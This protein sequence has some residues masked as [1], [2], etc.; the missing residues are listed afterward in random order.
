MNAPSNTRD[1]LATDYF[2]VYGLGSLGQGCVMNLQKFASQACPIRITA[3]DKVL[4]EKLTNVTAPG[5]LKPTLII[6]DYRDD[7]ILEQAGIRRC[8]SIL[9]LSDDENANIE[10]AFAA[11]R[12]NPLM[13]LVVRSS[14]P[15]LNRLLE[16]QLTNCAALDAAEL[17]ATAFAVAG[18]GNG[19]IGAFSIDE[20]Q[21]RVVERQVKSGDSRFDRFPTYPVGRTPYRLL[22]LHPAISSETSHPPVMD[23]SPVFHR[24]RS[25][26]KVKAGDWITYVEVIQA[27]DTA[28]MR[29]SVPSTNV[30]KQFWRF[31][32]GF[33]QL[34]WRRNLWQWIHAKQIRQTVFMGLV[35]AFCLELAGTLLLKYGAG[36]PWRQSV[37][38]SVIL[39]LGG[40]GDLFGAP[41]ANL[42]PWWVELFPLLIS[43]VS[44]LVVL[45]T[46]G[47]VAKPLLS[48]LFELLRK[49]R[50]I[51]QKGHVVV[52]GLG[53]IGRGVA[54]LMQEF[55]QPFVA[56]TT[57]PSN[58]DLFPEIPLLVGDIHQTLTKVNLAQAKSIVALTDD[59]IL[60]LEAV[61]IASEKA[62]NTG[63]ELGL[64]IRTQDQCL[65]ENLT[66]LLP[67]ATA[68]HPDVLSAQAYIAAAFGE[69]ILGFFPLHGRIILVTEH[70]ITDADTLV[71]K[72][73]A[74]V[75]YGY[76]VIPIF[77]QTAAGRLVGMPAKSL[78]PSDIERLRP[79]DRLVVLSSINSLRKIERGDIKP[80]RHWNLKI[81][82][83]LNRRL[84]NK[85]AYILNIISG[86]GLSK[87][88]A[89]MEALP[90]K[91]ELPLYTQQAYCLMQAFRGCG[92][93]N[94][95]LKPIT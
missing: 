46:L 87:A 92:L 74:E 88:K 65:S 89:F 93:L 47:L 45:G 37:F 28:A 91:I 51:P 62:R 38:S 34:Q 69:K 50:P 43:I 48:S 40:Y 42:V 54:S 79:G 80:P 85:A 55:K 7:K 68:L 90:G 1:C 63:R 77:Y 19:A 78:I 6:G 22:T 14:R 5:L 27:T 75:S 2:I 39:L 33:I 30:S 84:T 95:E 81:G 24:W 41:Q 94:A 15:S 83:P 82:S 29:A 49:R 31:F 35:M 4:P 52:I 11:R 57:H 67:S 56:L 53:R 25:D 17:S 73:L 76:D 36:L 70:H 66:A 9:L 16:R 13:R 61:L 32:R 26:A 59:Q 10:A 86:C 8:R 72:L 60:N 20:H 64:V 12:L 23:V 3:I 58:R 44:T 21:F 18:L 71:G